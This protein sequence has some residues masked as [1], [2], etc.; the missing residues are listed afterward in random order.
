MLCPACGFDESKVTESRSTGNEVRRRREC[1]KCQRRFTTKETIERQHPIVIKND[2]RREVFKID[3]IISGIETACRKR[4]IS[5]EQ[6]IDTA[7][8]IEYSIL[9][10]SKE[11]ISTSVIGTLVCKALEDLDKV[12]YIRFAS[13]YMQFENT[14]QFKD[15]IK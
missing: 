3:K 7:N 11:E 2:G 4:P 5:A 6:I 10:M 8:K 1:L 14:Q 9:N 12:A 13:V 15:F